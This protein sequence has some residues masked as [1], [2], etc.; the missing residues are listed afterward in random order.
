[1]TLTDKKLWLLFPTFSFKTPKISKLSPII[2]PKLSFPAVVACVAAE[3]LNE[4][5]YNS[6]NAICSLL[7]FTWSW[8]PESAQSQ[9]ASFNRSFSDSST[10]LSRLPW[11]RRA[12]NILEIW[13]DYRDYHRLFEGNQMTLTDRH[14]ILR[15]GGNFSCYYSSKKRQERNVQIM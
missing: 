7:V 3:W 1:M 8:I 12:S 9:V 13:R 4:K 15:S 14:F 6:K 10:F 2:S 5:A 11:T